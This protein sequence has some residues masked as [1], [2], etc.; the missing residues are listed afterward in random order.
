MT[1]IIIIGPTEAIRDA[2]FGPQDHNRH[3]MDLIWHRK[4]LN[5]NP[6]YLADIARRQAWKRSQGIGPEGMCHA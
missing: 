4:M 1:S 2:L 3:V 5:I 6:D